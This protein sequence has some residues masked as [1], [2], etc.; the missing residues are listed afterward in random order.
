MG[1]PKADRDKDENLHKASVDAFAIGTREVTLG[2]W[3]AV[4]N[5][6]PNGP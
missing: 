6:S 1:S 3:K 5:T 4:M 2:Q